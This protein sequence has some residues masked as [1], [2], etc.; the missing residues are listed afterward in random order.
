MDHGKA[1]NNVGYD[2]SK[3]TLANNI[4]T[5]SGALAYD[6]PT[7]GTTVIIVVDQAIHVTC[8]NK[9]LQLDLPKPSKDE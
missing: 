9:G 8:P 7:S 2:K 3:G 4:K 6:I 5:E 1:V